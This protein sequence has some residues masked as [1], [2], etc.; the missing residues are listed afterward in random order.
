MIQPPSSRELDFKPQAGMGTVPQD[1][2]SFH[3]TDMDLLMGGMEDMEVSYDH[4][5]YTPG[6]T[7]GD[8]PT[9]FPGP[10]ASETATMSFEH[11]SKRSGFL[12]DASSYAK[13]G[14]YSD[15]S[16]QTGEN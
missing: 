13:V 5:G 11:V 10:A 12:D 16:N 3:S 9:Y 4:A 2:S 7:M 8:E 14:A 1:N 6:Q 15:T